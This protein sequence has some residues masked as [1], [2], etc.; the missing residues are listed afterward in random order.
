MAVSS[1]LVPQWRLGPQPAPRS[2][3]GAIPAPHLGPPAVSRSRS[4]AIPTSKQ[5]TFHPPG[6][7][8]TSRGPTTKYEDDHACR[9]QHPF[10]RTLLRCEPAIAKPDGWVERRACPG[11]GSDSTGGVAQQKTEA[12]RIT[13]TA[14]TSTSPWNGDPV[15]DGAD[16]RSS[17]VWATSRAA[18]RSP[19]DPASQLPAPRSPSGASVPQ[20]CNPDLKTAHFSP[21]GGPRNLQGTNHQVRGRP[22]GLD[23]VIGAGG[24]PGQRVGGGV[25][26]DDLEGRLQAWESPAD[27]EIPRG[28]R[29]D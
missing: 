5:P 18:P 10:R 4:G 11:S 22:R 12:P 29:W 16:I 17:P 24:R 6:D 2:P 8:G 26:R 13:Q 3:R 20:R 25:V 7:Q 21:S 23:E 9:G 27:P 14:R 19:T 28:F 1:C 15:G